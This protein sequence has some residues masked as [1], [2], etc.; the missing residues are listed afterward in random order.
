ML[1]RRPLRVGD[2]VATNQYEGTVHDITLRTVLLVTFDGESVHIPNSMV[3]QNPFVNYTERGL[4]RTTLMV[5][6]AY[7]SD[8]DRCQQLLVE[9]AASVEGVASRPG[10]EALVTEFA[11]SA[12]S[13]AVRFWHAP[14]I[15]TLWRVR[16]EVARTVKRRLDQAGIVIPFP[17]RVVWL[18]SQG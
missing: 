13:F 11:D 4:R 10:P 15:A 9:A 16:D 17:Q 6:V 2:Q 14:D 8:L 5:G 1:I 12:V 3:W 18:R 7:D